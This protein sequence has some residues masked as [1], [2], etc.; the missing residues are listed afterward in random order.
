MECHFFVVS[1]KA[2]NPDIANMMGLIQGHGWC[3]LDS[4]Y[5]NLCY[6]YVVNTRNLGLNIEPNWNMIWFSNSNHALDQVRR[7]SVN[8]F[9]FY[10]LGVPMSWQIKDIK[11]HDFL[12]FRGRIGHTFG[13]WK[14]G[15]VCNPFI[16][17]RE[18][19][20][21][22]MAQNVT[23]KIYFKHVDARYKYVNE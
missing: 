4:I 6:D 9:I 21:N 22:V 17:K 5:W 12:E 7:K 10:V 18:C 20:K 1:Y 23:P 3:K 14:V 16:V 2:L 15:D 19:G 13:G 11:K 8:G